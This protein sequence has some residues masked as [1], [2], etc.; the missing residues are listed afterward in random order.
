MGGDEPTPKGHTMNSFKKT[1]LIGL[2]S[3]SLG[4]AMAPAHAQ[5]QEGRHSHAARLEKMQANHAAHAAE[6]LAKLHEKLKLTAAQEPA[7]T[8]FAASMTPAARPAVD[9]AAFAAMS[10]PERL[11]KHIA[12]SKTRIAAMES[13]L[14]AL[15]TFYAVLNADQKKIL[16]ESAAKMGRGRHMMMRMQNKQ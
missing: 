5:T 1:L 7:W 11:E 10:A 9:R 3:V 8:A 6:R 15:K 16:D 13:R 4:A 14:A 2:A 12:M